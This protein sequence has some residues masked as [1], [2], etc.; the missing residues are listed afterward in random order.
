MQRNI[1][2]GSV[3]T[4]GQNVSLFVSHAGWLTQRTMRHATPKFI[5]IDTNSAIVA[6]VY[7]LNAACEQK[8]RLFAK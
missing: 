3:A 2:R 6:R 8:N 5:E 4:I 7:P 1:R